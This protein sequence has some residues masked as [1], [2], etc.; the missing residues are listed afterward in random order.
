MLQSKR[1]ERMILENP[2]RNPV[3]EFRASLTRN[4]RFA[5]WITERVGTIGFFYAICGWTAGWLGWNA[6]G[7]KPLRFDPFPGFVLWL[8][9]ANVLQLVLMPLIMVGQNLLAL[10]SEKKAEVADE[11]RIQTTQEI[12]LI[13]THI[14]EVKA[15][16]E[17]QGVGGVRLG[18][19]AS[20]PMDGRK[21]PFPI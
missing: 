11:V 18:P 5:L 4:Q 14:N 1:L 7:P 12:S 10:L 9:V 16:L 15:L 13:L 8:F 21:P 6:F 2:I 19:E 3:E 17:G 20:G